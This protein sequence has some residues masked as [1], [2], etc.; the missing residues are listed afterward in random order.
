MKIALVCPYDWSKHGGVK[1]HV[2]ALVDFLFAN[3]D[4]RVFAPASDVLSRHGAD[5]VVQV[6]GRPLP[7]PYNR[8]VAPIGMCSAS[9]ANCCAA[10]ET[11]MRTS[12]RRAILRASGAIIR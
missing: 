5:R 12:R 9:D 2:A 4:V 6:I 1:A 8:S 3:H 7:V 11:A 10:G